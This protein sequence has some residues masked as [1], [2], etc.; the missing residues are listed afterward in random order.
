VAGKAHVVNRW[1]ELHNTRADFFLFIA[2]SAQRYGHRIFWLD[3]V[4]LFEA[5]VSE[6]VHRTTLSEIL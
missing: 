4:C 1:G 5:G 3:V 6:I 2:G